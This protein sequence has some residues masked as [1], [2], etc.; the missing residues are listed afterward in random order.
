MSQEQFKK[1]FP[2][3]KENQIMEEAISSAELAGADLTVCPICGVKMKNAKDP[4]TK[5][6]SKYI[7]FCPK[8]DLDVRISI[9]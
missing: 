7:F 6:I 8:C 1:K 2:Y 9:G 5:K 3:L 4:I